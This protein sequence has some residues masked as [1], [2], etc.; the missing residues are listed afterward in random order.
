[1]IKKIAFILLVLI[2]ADR[3]HGQSMPDKKEVENTIVRLF[4]GL[5]ALSEE[6]IQAEVTED[7]LLF[8]VG[9][10][11]NADSLVQAIAPMKKRAFSRKNYFQFVK[12][13]VKG[14][15]AWTSYDNKAEIEVDGRIRNVHWLESAV[16]IKQKGKWKIKFL[17]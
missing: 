5:S 4:E 3:A 9:E 6:K 16:L 8:E 13:E 14:D 17:H 7:F 15:M 1:M 10:V 11:W 2:A 12:T